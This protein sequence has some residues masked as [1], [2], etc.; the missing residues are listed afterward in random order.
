MSYYV[1]ILECGDGTFY[2]GQTNDLH[3][4][5]VEHQKGHGARYTMK[6]KP[7]RLVHAE[8]YPTRGFAMRREKE[9]KNLGR[10]GRER[11]IL[12]GRTTLDDFE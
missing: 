11:L 6:R 10:K 2:T 9:I 1:Y 8:K 3:R 5:L 12:H 4:R 7:V